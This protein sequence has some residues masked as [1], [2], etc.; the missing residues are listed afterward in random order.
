VDAREPV[1]H[2]A[3]RC[4]Q[5]TAQLLER[6]VLRRD[7]RV[8]QHVGEQTGDQCLAA[9]AEKLGAGRNVPT[10]FTADPVHRGFDV[11]LRFGAGGVDPVEHVER[12]TSGIRRIERHDVVPHLSL[13]EGLDHGADLAGGIEYHGGAAPGEHGGDADGGGLEPAGSTEDQGMG[14]AAAA[15]IDQQRCGAALAPGAAVHRVEHAACDAILIDPV[16]LT[17]DD[18]AMGIIR[19]GKQPACVAEG[20]PIGMAKIVGAAPHQ[21]RPRPAAQRLLQRQAHRRRW[22]SSRRRLLAQR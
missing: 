11:G 19:T 21:A 4:D 14:G 12:A 16:G 8:P 22:R 6:L 3:F 9:L 5:G 2:L 10:G 18:A 17:D 15:R 1:A 13:P 7:L 20:Q